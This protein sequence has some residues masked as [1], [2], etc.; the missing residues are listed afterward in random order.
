MGIL[1]MMDVVL[2]LF[3]THNSMCCYRSDII[4]GGSVKTYFVFYSI[5]SCFVRLSIIPFRRLE[6]RL[7]QSCLYQLIF[8]FIILFLSFYLFIVA[9]VVLLHNKLTTRSS[10]LQPLVYATITISSSLSSSISYSPSATIYVNMF[11]DVLYVFIHCSF[12]YSLQQP[13]TSYTRYLV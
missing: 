2:H 12:L 4:K 11:V 6:P 5:S 7:L 9:V 1:G 3:N 10:H 13:S 8:F